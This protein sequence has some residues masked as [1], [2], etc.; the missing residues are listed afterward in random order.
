MLEIFSKRSLMLECS[1]MTEPH[2]ETWD[3]YAKRHGIG[4]PV[5][6]KGDRPYY[7]EGNMEPTREQLENWAAAVFN[8]P[9]RSIVARMHEAATTAESPVLGQFADE[10]DAALGD[11]PDPIELDRARNPIGYWSGRAVAAEAEV[12]R[13]RATLDAERKVAFDWCRRLGL[14]LMS[15]PR[16]PEAISVMGEEV[17]AVRARVGELEEA[18]RRWEA[19]FDRWQDWRAYEALAAAGEPDEDRCPECS[20]LVASHALNGVGPCMVC[21]SCGPG[22]R[23]PEQEDRPIPSFRPDDSLTCGQPTSLGTCGLPYG[24]DGEHRM[25][26]PEQEK[27]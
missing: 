15:P 5:G 10:L 12:T 17:E 26:L 18:L 23:L 9:I 22:S 11:R 20:H 14:P 4:E 2:V 13:L 25:V 24:H 21:G 3:D 8:P 1:T 16:A 19:R 7:S 27:P 6:P